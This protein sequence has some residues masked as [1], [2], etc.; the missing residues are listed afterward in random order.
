VAALLFTGCSSGTA[1]PSQRHTD[2]LTATACR[3]VESTMGADSPFV[4]WDESAPYGLPFEK[5]VVA[6]RKAP[7]AKLHSEVLPVESAVSR[8]FVNAAPYT[9]MGSFNAMVLT[10][11]RL[12]FSYLPART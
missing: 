2:Q 8:H 11:I 6:V 3:V 7:N 9:F 1:T 5:V 12:G 4:T 10:C